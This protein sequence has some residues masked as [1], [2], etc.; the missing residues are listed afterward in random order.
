MRRIVHNDI[1]L[2]YTTGFCR[3]VRCKNT[4]ARSQGFHE[5]RQ[6]RFIHSGFLNGER[7]ESGI[8]NIPKHA[9]C[10]FVPG[11]LGKHLRQ[12]ASRTF[13][14]CPSAVVRLPYQLYRP[15]LL[16][17]TKGLA[18]GK[19]KAN[20]NT[21]SSLVSC[22]ILKHRPFSHRPPGEQTPR[23]TKYL[24][25]TPTLRIQTRRKY[26]LRRQAS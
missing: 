12:I 15:V 20:G 14:I 22:W 19:G 21:Q 9:P 7:N 1:H 8:Q 4:C 11:H 24:I 2:V 17:G 10:E 25:Q 6:P 16:A 26:P 3:N 18:L 13:G 23:P 5:H